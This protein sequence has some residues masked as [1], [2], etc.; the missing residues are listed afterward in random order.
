MSRTHLRYCLWF[1][2]NSGSCHQAVTS[3]WSTGEKQAECGLEGARGFPQLATLANL[4]MCVRAERPSLTGWELERQAQ[5]QDSGAQ[6]PL[7]ERS[8]SE[9][10]AADQGPS[11]GLG[12]DS[13]PLLLDLSGTDTT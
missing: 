11:Q 7:P 3:R 10:R 8:C 12:D 2:L 1:Y 5:A 6:A 4:R 9:P 13:G